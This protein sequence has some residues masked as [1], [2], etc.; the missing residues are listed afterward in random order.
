[1]EFR[2]TSKSRSSP[3]LVIFYLKGCVVVSCPKGNVWLHFE[4]WEATTGGSRGGEGGA[5]APPPP[6][7]LSPEGG[8]DFFL[9]I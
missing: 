6:P 3:N 1:M 5:A 7:P 9:Y 8:A 2:Q 4:P